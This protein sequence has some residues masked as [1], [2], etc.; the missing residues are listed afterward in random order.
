MRL[1]NNT[2]SRPTL[3][4]WSG[5]IGLGLIAVAV[6][7]ALLY[8]NGR[9]LSE[10]P[11]VAMR[12]PTE[13]D[14]S[15]DAP[16]SP[17]TA[18]VAVALV[19]E[20]PLLP[21]LDFLPG[22]IEEACGLNDFM[23]YH[24]YDPDDKFD[25]LSALESSACW[26]ALDEHISTINPYLWGETNTDHPLAFLV[27]ENPLTFGRIFADPAGDLARV[28]DAL[29]RSECLLNHGSE[30]N[31]ELKENCHADALLNYALVNRFCFDEG[32]SNRNRTFY[33]EEDN[34]TPEQDRFMWKQRLENAWVRS[35]CEEFAPELQLTV[36]QY[37]EL[38]N[39]LFS[40]GDPESV[41]TKKT[42]RE[43][44]DPETLITPYLIPTLIE[45]AARLGDDAAGLTSP[46]TLFSRFGPSYNEEG[47]KFGRFAE[48]L[49]SAEWAYFSD[50]IEPSID[51]FLR[52]FHFIT[53][54]GARRPDPRDE[55]QFDWEW[56]AKHL[57]DP[58]YDNSDEESESEESAKPQSC[59]EIVHELRQRDFKFQPL[60]QT[61]DKFEQVALELDVYE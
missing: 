15:A 17:P 3:Y 34:P 16:S 23:P 13:S 58:P 6:V 22:S 36:E 29:S 38:T 33:W 19:E 48:L 5:G 21:R 18:V 37:P 51:R 12:E 31:L 40:L 46:I 55:L 8:A 47:Y 53:R 52:S 41:A 45:H 28:Q 44:Y 35:K 43:M 9:T 56:V 14:T 42:K 4:Y 27:L 26:T 32:V 1:K 30:T 61:L 59:Q 50:K 54:V 10:S 39:L 2:N 7:C 49:K 60:L 20:E 57:C 25:W 24:S 11:S